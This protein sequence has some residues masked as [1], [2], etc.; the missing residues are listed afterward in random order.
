MKYNVPFKKGIARAAR[1]KEF[2]DM[3]YAK[4]ALNYYV[5]K[6]T[7]VIAARSGRVVEAKSSKRKLSLVSEHKTNFVVIQHDDRTFAQ[8]LHLFPSVRKGQRILVE[9]RIG[10]TTGGDPQFKSHLHFNV[11]KIV[12]KK[13]VS[14]RVTFFK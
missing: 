13:P 9:Q 14:V 11:F 3:P 2:A 4:H 1:P 6:G 10:R 8:Y 5:R 7:P 12:K